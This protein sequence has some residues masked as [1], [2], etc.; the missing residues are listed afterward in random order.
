M[1]D[2]NNVVPSY[3]HFEYLFKINVWDFCPIITVRFFFSYCIIFFPYKRVEHFSTNSPSPM[4]NYFW[5]VT[6]ARRFCSR[7]CKLEVKR[8]C[9]C[10]ARS[11]KSVTLTVSIVYKWSSRIVLG[12][13]DHSDQSQVI[14]FLF[15]LGGKTNPV[16]LR[17]DLW[18]NAQENP[19]LV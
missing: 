3:N 14:F 5:N 18:F 1:G 11:I 19:I 6:H 12:L 8:Y 4:C 2:L 17:T 7:N 10:I 9:T 16:Q 15:S 13:S